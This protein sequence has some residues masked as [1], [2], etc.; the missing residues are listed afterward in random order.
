[1]TVKIFGLNCVQVLA[2][3]RSSRDLMDRLKEEKEQL[4]QELGAIKAIS[5]RREADRKTE[6]RLINILLIE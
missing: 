2:S 5:S 1:M 4:E 3:N 6:V